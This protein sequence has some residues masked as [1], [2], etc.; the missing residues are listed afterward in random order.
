MKTLKLQ[1]HYV[2]QYKSMWITL[3]TCIIEKSVSTKFVEKSAKDNPKQVSCNIWMH[4]L[5]GVYYGFQ[6]FRRIS[7]RIPC[8]K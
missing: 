1:R 5:M 2:K 8:S 6:G 4:L 3:D 7:H